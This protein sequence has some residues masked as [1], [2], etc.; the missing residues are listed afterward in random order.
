[1][2]HIQDDR[3]GPQ[4]LL[5]VRGL[6][7]EFRLKG[8]VVR[9]VTDMSFDVQRA[10]VVGLVGESGSGKSVSMLSLLG[11][12]PQPPGRIV[13]GS[14][15]FEGRDLLS[16]TTREMRD[17]RGNDIG[18]VFQDPMTSLNPVITIGAQVVEAVR[19]HGARMTRREARARGIELLTSVGMPQASE[20]MD[21]Y[22]HAFSGGMR[23]RVMIAISIANSPKLLLAD[24]PTTALDVTTQ[25]QVLETLEAS[26]REKGAAMILITH[27]M[28]LV[29]DVADR[30]I[31]MYA[32]RIMEEGTAEEIFDFPSHP[33]TSGLLACLPQLE[34]RVPHMSVVPGTLANLADLPKGC[35][36]HPRCEYSLDPERC[37][38]VIPALLPKADG[39]NVACHFADQLVGKLETAPEELR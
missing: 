2:T 9:A 21:D 10:E 8:E 27:N 17:V 5:S 15:M 19:T 31:V 38:T 37:A 26:R 18:M 14:A 6:T 20:R 1:M 28:G 36:F 16:L 39:R 13:G 11:L 35:V 25:A 30:I 3:D 22:P 24:E 12:V 32:S 7:V 33:Y 34:E 4:A 29:A 23:Q